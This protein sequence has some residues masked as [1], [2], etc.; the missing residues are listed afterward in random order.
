MVMPGGRIIF[1]TCSVLASE[2]VQQIN[3]VLAEA[4]ELEL[5]DI[6]EIW[7]DT[8]GAQKGGACPP[9]DEGMLR[10]LPGRDGTD[11]FFMAVIQARL[12]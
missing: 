1:I 8:I 2:S 3:R 11:G 12:R 4:P 5:A 7:Q 6:G 10:L 9:L